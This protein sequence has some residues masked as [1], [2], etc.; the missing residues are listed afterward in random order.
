MDGHHRLHLQTTIG[1]VRQQVLRE[2][3]MSAR[4]IR[5]EGPPVVREIQIG[6]RENAPCWEVHHQHR[7][8]VRQ[9]EHVIQVQYF[10]FRVIRRVGNRMPL[11]VT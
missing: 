10:S 2:R 7:G 4:F 11:T 1:D 9:I 6:I 5:R 3:R 8:R